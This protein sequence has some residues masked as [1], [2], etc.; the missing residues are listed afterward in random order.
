MRFIKRFLL[1]ILSTLAVLAA[2]GLLLP[3]RARMER[4]INVD[5][6]PSAV[7]PLI[8]DFREF[9]RW[10]PWF[11]RDPAAEF[12]YSTPAAGKGASMSWRSANPAVGHGHQRIV[13]ARR[14]ELV[15]ILLEFEGQDGA[16]STFLLAPADG[17]SMLTWRFDTQFGFDLV[18]RYLGLFLDRWLGPEFEQGLS[19]IKRLAEQNDD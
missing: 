9:N 19:N 7:F 6:P 13:A 5:A 10:S 16:F 18:G 2:T 4:S 12:R 3:D 1:T 17:G 8:S 11:A 14:D 15:K